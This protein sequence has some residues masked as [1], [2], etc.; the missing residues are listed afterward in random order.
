M[1]RAVGLKSQSMLS[2]SSGVA[3]GLGRA[4]EPTTGLKVR[5]VPTASP[6]A[7][8][9]SCCGRLRRQERVRRRRRGR[10]HVASARNPVRYG[11]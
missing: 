3:Y 1:T 9:G 7:K 2:G 5:A 4:R 11:A 10:W 8:A 6:F